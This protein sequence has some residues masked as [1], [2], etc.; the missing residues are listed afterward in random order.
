M[1]YCMITS[2]IP[3]LKILTCCLFLFS[4]GSS[5]QMSLH[6]QNN[7]ARTPGPQG[8][9]SWQQNQN[10]KT[11][12]TDQIVGSSMRTYTAD[13]IRTGAL[14]QT[15]TEFVITSQHTSSTSRIHHI[16]IR[17]QLNGIQIY[18]ADGDIHITSEGK[19]LQSHHSFIKSAN[20]RIVGSTIP[21]LTAIEALN[22]AS[23][24]LGM[25]TAP[26]EVVSRSLNAEQS[27]VMKSSLSRSPIPFQLMYH[28][29]ENKNLRLS[30]D[31]SIESET[32]SDWWS[33]RIDASSGALLD[34]VNWTV[35]CMT[36]DHDH[37]H[38]LSAGPS[39]NVKRPTSMSNASAAVG[40]YE[41]FASPDESPQHGSTSRSIVANP[42][43]GS[44]AGS[45]FGWHDTNGVAGSEFTITRGNNVFA[46]EDGDN[47]G[48]SPNGGADLNFTTSNTNG[49]N[50][51]VNTNYSNANQSEDAA[52]TNLF[53]WTNII[54]DMIYVFGMDEAAGNFQ[55]TNYTGAGQGNDQ[56]RAEAQDGSGTC[57]ANFQTPPDG[58]RPRMQ[59][60]ICSNR[61]GDYDNGIIA[62]EYGHGISTRLTGGAAAAGCLFGQEQMGEGW[63]DYYGMVMTIQP[64]DVPDGG[65]RR[66]GMGTYLFR[67]GPNGPGIRPQP[68]S[69]DIVNGNNM[70]YDTIK[71]NVAVPHGVGAVWAE[72]LWEVTWALIN[73]H[74]WDPDYTN[75]S[76][77]VNSDG[78]NVQSLALVTEGLK[79]QPCG[80][81]FVTSR[82]AIIQA[83]Q[84]IYGG[85]NNC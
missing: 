1:K 63:S 58:N 38:D 26:A 61:D 84:I 13:L 47:Q 25:G 31:M 42:D 16:Y 83:D 12:A 75:F 70:T 5:L 69:T 59:M 39:S 22:R 74:G 48:Y 55:Q 14:D 79:L 73:E 20:S 17:Q 23:R 46:Y 77:N 51:S 85:A 44:V 62:H 60:F 54:H 45:P 81:G 50:F 21:Q 52:I 2:A 11:N 32:N 35:E 9:V 24:S 56:I 71:G 49:V 80:P 4:L 15:D 36:D 33:L 41:V 67:Q 53:Y 78:G 66:R 82:D 19:S 27:G 40:N 65:Q 57:N 76:G 34:T 30:W 29:D 37:V 7:Q 72:I 28:I 43:D 18:G 68:Y 6:A 10:D 64:E 3:K 8:P